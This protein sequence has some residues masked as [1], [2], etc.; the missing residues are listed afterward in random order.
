MYAVPVAACTSCRLKQLL[1]QAAATTVILVL[2]PQNSHATCPNCQKNFG[3]MSTQMSGSMPQLWC[4]CRSQISICSHF[5]NFSLLWT[6]ISNFGLWPF[7]L[8]PQVH[9]KTL[10][11]GTTLVFHFGHKSTHLWHQYQNDGI[12]ISKKRSRNSKPFANTYSCIKLYCTAVPYR[13]I[14]LRT[15]YKKS[16]I[17]KYENALVFRNFNWYFWVPQKYSLLGSVRFC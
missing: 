16:K 5:W 4:V 12:H 14:R 9:S 13:L 7:W 6:Q 17:R 11:H 1:L 3:H 15:V 2:V 10:A 8:W